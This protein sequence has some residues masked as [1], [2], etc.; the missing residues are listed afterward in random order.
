MYRLL[1]ALNLF[2]ILYVNNG[3]RKKVSDTSVSIPIHYLESPALY[4]FISSNF[5]IIVLHII[6]QNMNKS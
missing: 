5:S 6:M 1:S 4:R 2:Y 3:R